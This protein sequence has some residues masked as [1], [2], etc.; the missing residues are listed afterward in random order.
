MRNISQYLSRRNFNGLALAGIFAQAYPWKLGV[1]TDQ[2]DLDLNRA[3]S[4]FF[5]AYQLQWA[6]IRYLELDH[7]KSYVYADATPSQLKEIR[8]RLDGSGVQLSVLDTAIFKI[9]LPGTTPA[10]EVPAYVGAAESGYR[11]QLGQLKRAAEAAHA[12]GTDRLR[13][14]TF[15]RVAEPASVFPRV[16]EELQKAL[17]VA[18]SV[19]V[20]LLVE[21][22]Y[23]CNTGSGREIA[24]LF[25][26]IPDRRLMHNWDPCNAYEMGEEPFPGIWNQLDH[27]RISHIHLKDAAGQDWKPIGTG[28]VNLAGQFKALKAINYAGTMSLETRY[29]NPLADQ[30]GSTVESMNGLM[31]LWKEDKL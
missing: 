10:G 21:N 14:F 4:S 11:S 5:P 26:T 29:K 25:R 27:S 9:T 31:K 30:Y 1:I 7:K 17:R 12:L 28:K 18:S 6:E 3:L 20:R 19:D 23:D 15:R 22:E 8:R 16:V 2:V 24:A 13:I